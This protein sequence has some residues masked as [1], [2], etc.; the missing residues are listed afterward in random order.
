MKVLILSCN[1]GG[2]HNTAAKAI[3]EYFDLLGDECIIKDALAFGGQKASD[4]VCDSYI[5]IVKRTPKLFGDFYALG[6]KMGQYNSSEKK[7][8]SP[9]Y[10][11]NKIYSDALDDYIKE[12]DFDAIIC[13]HIFP[14]EALTHLK[15]R[16]DFKKTVFFVSTDYAASPMLEE[17]LVDVIFAPHKDSIPTFTRKGISAEKIIPSGIPVAQTFTTKLDKKEARMQLGLSE[18][19]KI[20]LVMTGSM[21]FGDTLE[22][23]KDILQKA[24]KETH[25]IVITGNNQELYD[26]IKKMYGGDDRLVLVGFTKQ[27]SLYM[28]ASDVFLSKPGGLSSTEA[29]VKT[30]PIVH[31]APIPGCESENVSFFIKH[32]LSICADTTEE[33]GELAV[34]MLQDSFLR[35][36]VESAQKNYK[37]ENSARFIVEYIKKYIEKK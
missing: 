23:T 24:D 26:D 12:E 37:C 10:L 31:T 11:I 16:H 25:L 29:L 4:L 9:I 8:R 15:R 13:T 17:T 22:M 20:I 2:G 7:I 6:K 21:G 5:E 3:K 36:Q 33:A 34:R 35:K 18:K 30:I 27:V 19:G 14:A 1:T 28:D 32:H